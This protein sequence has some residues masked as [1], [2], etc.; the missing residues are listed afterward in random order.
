MFVDLLP[1]K[2][3]LFLSSGEATINDIGLAA[4]A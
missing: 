3:R 2:G 4:L 1:R